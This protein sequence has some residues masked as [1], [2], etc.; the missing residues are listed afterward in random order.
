MIKSQFIYIYK[1][2]NFE[3][4][5]KFF[6]FI[7]SVGFVWYLY[8]DNKYTEN[9][10]ELFVSC[11]LCWQDSGRPPFLHTSLGKEK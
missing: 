2:F 11:P 3:F 4:H 5:I 8:D 9:T 1:T 10:P 7:I 6:V